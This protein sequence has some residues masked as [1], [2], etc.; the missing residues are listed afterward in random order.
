M[1][2]VSDDYQCPWCG[3]KGMGGYAVD[4]IPY[5]LCTNG[6]NACAFTQTHKYST[7]SEYFMDTLLLRIG[8]KPGKP[9][10]P[11]HK[12]PEWVWKVIVGFLDDRG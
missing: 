10:Q 2:S 6:K 7:Q 3:R 8:K 9:A 5:P 1:G 4:P 11:I 12:V